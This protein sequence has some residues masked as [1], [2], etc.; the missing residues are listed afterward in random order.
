MIFQQNKI[1]LFLLSYYLNSELEKIN[2][3]RKYSPIIR[4]LVFEYWK[5]GGTEN[6]KQ[7]IRAN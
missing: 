6:R 4:K 5:Y 7:L 2:S 1:L 3:V